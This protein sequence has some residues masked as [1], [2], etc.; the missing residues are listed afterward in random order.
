MNLEKYLRFILVAL[1]VVLFFVIPCEKDYRAAIIIFAGA[2]MRTP[3]YG[4][5]REFAGTF[6][7]EV[8]FD[9]QGTGRLGNKILSGQ[10]PDIFIPASMQWAGILE[11]KGL[12]KDIKPLAYHTPVIITRKENTGLNNISDVLNPDIKIALC[13]PKADAIGVNSLDILEKAG[14]DHRT[15]NVVSRAFTVKTLVDLVEKKYADAAIVWSADAKESA[16]LRIIDIP[17]EFNTVSV[18]CVCTMKRESEHP[19]K[20][21][22]IRYFNNFITG[23]G[24]IFFALNGFKLVNDDSVPLSENSKVAL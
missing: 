1:A 4:L 14:I 10:V 20:L 8:I 7:I 16:D 6:G 13:D 3:L 11:R 17:V 21:E 24:K 18:I 23:E 12:I 22:G 2:G 9:F 19:D 15:L 5:G